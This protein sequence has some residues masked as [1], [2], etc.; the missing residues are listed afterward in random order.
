MLAT[1]KKWGNSYAVRLTKKDL[2]RMGLREGQ[3]VQVIV[4]PAIGQ[5][6]PLDLSDLPTFHDPLPFKQAREAAYRARQ[7]WE[8]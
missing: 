8:T 7:K 6:E 4:Q 5:A 2:S 1:V 3:R